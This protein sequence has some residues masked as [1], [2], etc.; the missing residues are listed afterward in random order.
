[1]RKN[2]INNKDTISK[3]DD[4]GKEFRAIT[5]RLSEWKDYFP[6]LQ[7]KLMLSKGLNHC[8][9]TAGMLILG[10]L[11]TKKNLFLILQ[12]SGDIDNQ[13][14]SLNTYLMYEIKRDYLWK[15]IL[16]GKRTE[17]DPA[18]DFNWNFDENA[19]QVFPL[20]NNELINRL[21]GK[22]VSVDYHT[23][24]GELLKDVTINNNF[25]SVGNYMDDRL[26]GPVVV[27]TK[28]I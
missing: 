11:M 23:V 26:I 16:L 19:F 18:I 10:Y 2:G 13:L 20:V 5:L 4:P 9:D 24:E 7:C 28:M 21:C 22:E 12:C 6:D 1:M 27:N 14:D 3:N 8:V 25:C 15:E 17:N